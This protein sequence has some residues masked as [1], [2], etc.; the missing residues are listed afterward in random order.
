MTWTL[1]WQIFILIF[2]VTLM[3]NIIM[4]GDQRF[5]EGKKLANGCGIAC[6]E[7]HQYDKN[8]RLG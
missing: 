2:W 1:F 7:G 8:C 4:R 5:G 3:L 6:S